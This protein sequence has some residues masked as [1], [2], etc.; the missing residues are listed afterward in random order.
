[1]VRDIWTVD[2]LAQYLQVSK[3]W[4]YKRTGRNAADPIPRCPG[5]GKPRFNTRSP[6]FQKW[7]ENLVGEFD[8]V[9]SNRQAE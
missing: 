5:I 2:D 3:R 9:D 4:V 1:M 7:L 8:D 6:A